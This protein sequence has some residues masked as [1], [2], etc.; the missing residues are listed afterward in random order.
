M[1]CYA[2][3][4]LTGDIV[5]LETDESGFVAVCAE[6]WEEGDLG[7]SGE[8]PELAACVL[9]SGA[10]GVF[11]SDEGEPCGQLGLPALSE[12][13][14]PAEATVIGLGDAVT[15]IFL[16]QACIEPSEARQ[17]VEA[18][19]AERGLNDWQVTESTA[20]S[21]ARPCASVSIDPSAK[22]VSLIPI[23]PKPER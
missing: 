4:D 8:A 22:T 18:A 13:P 21:D 1:G 11:P 23:P 17:V 20:Y 15:E 9:E 14:P 5:V 2:E 16:A 6:A 7:T 10:V 12:E 19:L 3:V